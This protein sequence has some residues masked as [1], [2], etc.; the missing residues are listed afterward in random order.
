M[1]SDGCHEEVC[2]R[3]IH[4]SCYVLDN[5][6]S[7]CQLHNDMGQAVQFIFP[8]ILVLIQFQMLVDCFK[9]CIVGITTQNQNYGR[10]LVGIYR[11]M[12]RYV[13][14]VYFMCISTAWP[15]SSKPGWPTDGDVAYRAAQL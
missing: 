13:L 2:P 15:R 5:G 14:W 8:T 7:Y 10:I 6:D 4:P 9:G 1:V 12:V 11:Y 3:N